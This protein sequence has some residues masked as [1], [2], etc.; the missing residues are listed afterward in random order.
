LV[1]GG[2]AFKL[3]AAAGGVVTLALSEDRLP[4]RQS[5][6]SAV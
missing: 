2:V 3:R 4:L 6:V 1:G 5:G